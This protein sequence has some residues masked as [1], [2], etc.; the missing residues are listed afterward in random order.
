MNKKEIKN[1]KTKPILNTPKI[2]KVNENKNQNLNKPTERKKIKS[3]IP[4]LK[5]TKGFYKIKT[6]TKLNNTTTH[7]NQNSENKIKE[8]NKIIE[9]KNKEI[10]ELNETND[11][12]IIIKQKEIMEKEKKIEKIN[13]EIIDLTK[14]E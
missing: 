14:K 10:K 13:K 12:N 1:G 8:L 9:E 4:K 11:K 6:E 5:T 2:N 7:I 3:G